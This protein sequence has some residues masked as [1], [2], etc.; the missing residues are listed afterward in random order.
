MFVHY[1]QLCAPRERERE[2]E[3]ERERNRKRLISMRGNLCATK[4]TVQWGRRAVEQLKR[5]KRE[6]EFITANSNEFNKGGNWG[7]IHILTAKYLCVH[8]VRRGGGRRRSMG[9][10]QLVGLMELPEKNAKFQLSSAQNIL[11]LCNTSPLT[12]CLFPL[13]TSY[14]ICPRNIAPFQFRKIFWFHAFYIIFHSF[15]AAFVVAVRTRATS[16]VKVTL[17]ISDNKLAW[18]TQARS[19]SPPLSPSSLGHENIACFSTSI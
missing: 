12:C 2:G 6:V 1:K 9:R 13:L 14:I 5:T 19:L 16:V 17:R 18:P 4:H 10:R 8:A 11:S 7:Y 15:L 3:R